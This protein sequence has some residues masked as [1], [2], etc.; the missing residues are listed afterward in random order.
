MTIESTQP[1]DSA[2]LIQHLR[3][4]RI[5]LWLRIAACVVP[6]ALLLAHFGQGADTFPIAV[7]F[8][9][10]FCG[11]FVAVIL[12]DEMR[13][14]SLAMSAIGGVFLF[15]LWIGGFGNWHQ[16]QYEV[17]TLVGGGALLGTGFVI[18]SRNGTL[19]V[20]WS[21][22]IWSLAL[23]AVVS[24]FDYLTQTDDVGD[25]GRRLSA[26]FGSANSAAT[27]FAMGLLLA[28]A[29]LLVR[30]QDMR[31]NKRQ[32]G[33]R[34]AYLA[35]YEFPSLILMTFAAA[36]LIMTMSR[37]GILMGVLS[38][39]GL[40]GF[41]LVRMT[42]RGQLRFLRRRRVFL[43]LGAGAVLVVLLAVSG[44]INPQ[45][46]EELLH[47]VEGRTRTFAIYWDLWL[48]KPWFGY[49]LGSFNSVIDDAATLQT[50]DSLT[51]MGAAHNVVLQWLLQQG[52][53]GLA[54]MVLVLT[55]VFAPIVRALLSKSSKPRHFLRLTIALTFL[56]FGHG[57]VD[58]ALEI[59]S[60]MWTYAFILGLAAGYSLQTRQRRSVPADR[61]FRDR[62][63]YVK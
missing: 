38:F 54:A 20:A 34:V 40:A 9:L 15:W 17:Q 48:Q 12:I 5:H 1:P 56:V 33:E 41:E 27:L 62:A 37:A 4:K 39:I 60:I 24:G 35:Q 36:C 57:M 52:I 14:V 30:F 2:E 42:R 50:A 51:Q 31:Y 28:S 23:F 61:P 3:Q 43:L 45:H 21:A 25:Y 13:A 7:P 63:G 22:L 44:E 10:L 29:K 58:Y 16:A 53:L 46:A 55:I 59:P 49:G 8:V 47:N 26:G 6:V 11:L 19:K 32:R 18:G